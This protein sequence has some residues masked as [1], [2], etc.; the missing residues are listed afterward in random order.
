M[1]RI[2]TRNPLLERHGKAL[3]LFGDRVRSVRPG[4]WEDGTPC[5]E[6][7]VRDLV[8]HLT[9]EQL[10]V[11]PLLREGAT[12]DEV[13]DRYDGDVLGADPVA[14][15]ERAAEGSREAFATPGVFDGTVQLSYGETAVTHY[16][17]E[18]ICDLVVHAWDL[19][20]AIGAEERLPGDLVDFVV[21]QLT[22]RAADLARSGL[23]APPVE[24]PP[25][26]TVQTKL[27]C[28]VGRRP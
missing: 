2:A 5:E 14:A 4:Q 16:C 6:W 3:D 8:N 11:P 27:L 15:W 20:R 1:P 21:R 28:L 18:M 9:S 10:W 24:P 17:A 25:E 7:N 12:L 13:G 26:A 23:F 22:P 19:S